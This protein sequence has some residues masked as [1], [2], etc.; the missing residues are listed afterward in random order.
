MN[1][2][3]GWLVETWEAENDGRREWGP[4]AAVVDPGRTAAE[5]AETFE[6]LREAVRAACA[7]EV[8]W[9]AKI[10]S[11]VRAALDFVASEPAATL[12]LA[13]GQDE[14]CGERGDAVIG[15]FSE[16][17][18][19]AGPSGCGYGVSTERAIVSSLAGVVRAHLRAATT[20]RL[21]AMAPELVLL[22]RLPY[23]AS[24]ALAAP[25]PE[26]AVAS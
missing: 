14:V 5:P 2:T 18:G 3:R 10:D 25:P 17:L 8:E 16:L 20:D 4:G 21:P 12:A 24:A 13:E 19:S 26:V 7:G 15:Y 1:L 9:E 23:A 11:G 6:R 22:T